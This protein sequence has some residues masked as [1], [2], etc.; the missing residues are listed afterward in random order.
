MVHIYNDIQ[1]QHPPI[2]L[3]RLLRLINHQQAQNHIQ[4]QRHGT[5]EYI[6]YWTNI[7]QD[8]DKKRNILFWHASWSKRIHAPQHIICPEVLSLS[9]HLKYTC[10]T[11]EISSEKECAIEFKLGN[12]GKVFCFRRL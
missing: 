4:H 3:H 9:Q 10:S 7:L 1:V 2:E 11:A 6:V 12:Y 8:H 5:T